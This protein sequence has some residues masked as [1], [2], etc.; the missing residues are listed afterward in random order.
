M[1]L[2]FN[3]ILFLWM[4]AFSVKGQN[5]AEFLPSDEIFCNP[6]RGFYTQMSTLASDWDMLSAYSLS[7]Y[8]DLH[9][10]YSSGF[11]TY[12][13]LI[14][15]MV[16]L[17]GFQESPLP[18]SVMES[19]ESD[20]NLAREYG[21]KLILRFAYIDEVLGPTVEDPN[22][23]YGD[24][25]L[26]NVLLHMGQLADVIEENVDVIALMQLG[27]IGAYGEGYYTDYF[28]SPGD[29]GFLSDEDWALRSLVLDSLLS[30]LPEDRMVQVRTPQMKQKFIHGPSAPT[31]S[32]TM[33]SAYAYSGV[34][35]ARIGF[36]IDCML[37]S[38]DDYGTYNDLGH[39]GQPYASADTTHL[40]P[41]LRDESKFVVVGGETCYDGYNP[42]NNCSETDGGQVQLELEQ[43]HVSFLNSTYN[44]DVNNDWVEGGCIDEINRRLGYRFEL[45]NASMV[46]NPDASSMAEISFSIQNVGFAAPFNPREV[47][48]V[49]RATDGSEIVHFDVNSDPRTWNPGEVVQVTQHLDVE[50]LPSGVYEC[51]LFLKDP[52]M[53]V[54]SHPKYAIRIASYLGSGE[55]VWDD[56]LGMNRLGIVLT[57][58]LGSC[59]ADINQDGIVGVDDLLLLLSDFGCQESCVNDI[60][61]DLVVTVTDLLM[62]LGAFG[63]DCPMVD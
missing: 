2:R 29:E 46:Y 26:D 53:S 33:D 54:S 20:F 3:F 6:E 34:N 7:V 1:W 32:S 28:G 45:L 43:M 41:Y 47:E 39:S 15:R 52:H 48:V 40:R 37:S 24:S 13:S 55:D 38:W 62:I 27:F 44:N 21:V 35:E 10:P 51:L 56:T 8:S 57:K 9:T 18:E 60:D 22:A 59:H 30:V 17:D 25:N 36:H 5:H 19:L 23:L 14:L 63:A 61:D 12:N 4:F 42:Q 16:I 11:Q 58:G 31:T 49:L 50:A